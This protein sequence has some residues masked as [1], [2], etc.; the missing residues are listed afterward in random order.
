MIK[1]SIVK[2]IDNEPV[3]STLDLYENLGVEHSAIIKLIRKYEKEF[4]QI[5]TL[6]F[7]IHKSGGRPTSYCYLNEEQ[8]LSLITLMRNSEIVVAFKMKITSEFIRMR[9]ALNSLAVQKQNQQWIETR[10]SGKQNRRIETDTIKLF[11][12]YSKN[13]GSQNAEKYYANIT[14]MEYK[15]LFLLEQKFK[16]I[17]DVLN[18]K[19]LSIIMNADDIV[20]KA[21]KDG[22][23]NNMDY[24]EIYQLAKKRVESFSEL[25]GKEIIPC[26]QIENK[27]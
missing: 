18:I 2:I 8:A 17:R 26:F 3:V 27:G 16:N 20:S 6:G 25:R 5:R 9:N 24:K 1:N 12:E 14:N 19:Q 22:M 11:I 4:N 15:A 23:E 13:Q 21:L 7:E 10:S